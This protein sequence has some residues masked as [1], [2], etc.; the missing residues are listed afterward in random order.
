MTTIATV[1]QS[2]IDELAKLQLPP[3]TL[4]VILPDECAGEGQ[5]TQ[6][7]A[8][9][10]PKAILRRNGRAVTRTA[11]VERQLAP[12][13]ERARRELTTAPYDL[14]AL[15]EGPLAPTALA[16][17]FVDALSLL[18]TVPAGP[19]AEKGQLAGQLLVAE[20][21][22]AGQQMAQALRPMAGQLAP[23]LPVA[24][25]AAPGFAK[26]SPE[27]EAAAATH[28]EHAHKVH[29][30]R[31]QNQAARDKAREEL[32]GRV[33]SAVGRMIHQIVNENLQSIRRQCFENFNNPHQ[34]MW[35]ALV[36]QAPADTDFPDLDLRVLGWPENAATGLT[37]RITRQ[38]QFLRFLHKG[39]PKT[40]DLE[41]VVYAHMSEAMRR[42]GISA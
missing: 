41:D 35:Q 31:K 37:K 36:A 22:R 11:A 19:D 7:W 26:A 29:K 5:I 33:N 9:G 4:V 25:A 16:G 42:G 13:I 10:L 39:E 8:D 24:A 38:G 21:W 30:A 17:G 1:A 6:A 27:M 23:D 2:M 34:L 32:L 15:L 28:A 3:G 20:Q 12:G 18:P 14:V 40:A